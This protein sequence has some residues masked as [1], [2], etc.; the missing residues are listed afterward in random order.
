VNRQ[1]Y[2]DALINLPKLG[3]TSVSPDRRWAAWTWFGI[4][5]TA[6][7][8]AAPT[9]LSSP[10][11][12][13]TE[14]DEDA[15]L[16]S[17]TPDSRAVIVG[18]D[19]DGD[20]R[21]QLF[22]VDLDRPGTLLPLTEPHPPY[23]LRG[24]QLHPNG[25]WLVYAMNFDVEEG[26]E[27]EPTWIYRHNLVTGERLPLACPRKA[28]YYV[29][30]LNDAGTHVL[31][32]RQDIDPAGYQVW[33]VDIEGREDREI[34]NCGPATKVFASWYPDSVHVLV[35][36]EAGS[37]R[38]LGVWDRETGETHWL[39]DDPARNIEDAFVP[40]GSKCAVV[41]E[42][43]QARLRASLLDVETGEETR[44][45]GIPGN[46]SPRRPVGNGEWI[47]RYYSATQP[48]DLLRFHVEDVRPAE[49][50]SL[51][52]VWERTPLRSSD[53]T[54]AQTFRWRSVDGLEIQ[55]WLYRPRGLSRGTIVNVH[56]GPTHHYEDE[57]SSQ[58]QFYV[59]QGFN[60][61]QPNYRGSTGFGLPFMEA[62]KEDGW[63]GREQDDI[64][65]G[66]E[67]LIGAGIAERGRIGVTGTSYGGYSAWCAI[68]RF[69]PEIVAAAA[70]IC[71]MTDLVVDYETTR[72][73]LRPY[74]EEMLGG[75]P[76]Q[77][78]DRY[79][80]RSP[81]HFVDRIRGKLLI[82][83]GLRDPNVTPENVRAV[84][85]ALDRAG[86]EYEILTFEDEGHGIYHP[87]NLK[88]LYTRL[89]DFFAK[90]FG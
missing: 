55:G 46:L 31:Y 23:F 5:P 9:D 81:V 19:H 70:P 88:V 49:F 52:R 14:T 68:T 43:E 54:P 15:I 53:L 37:Y 4:G 60:V 12:R 40:R 11:I 56:G 30:E 28:G 26:R 77:V 42:I 86:I 8:F 62:I 45:P 72:P 38:K 10:P 6:D 66:I 87:Y 65:T 73:D 83:Q 1:D 16:T 63:G 61:L 35:L 21:V 36:A 64:C 82:V 76:D 79:R 89:V 39:L 74:S 85:E 33:L 50:P 7:V 34:V 3:T 57:L 27:I 47:G 25:R 18:Q 22:H 90:S 51:T 75:R 29:P 78:P 32:H 59:A 44:L 80:E 2:L 58:V 24:G 20:E 67:A 13:L 48:D 69:P 41:I 71:G 17:W 84:R